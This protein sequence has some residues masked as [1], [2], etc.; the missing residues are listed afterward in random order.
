MYYITTI[1]VL[2]QA[3]KAK[4]IAGAGNVEWY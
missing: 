3:A 1:A 4:K 2:A